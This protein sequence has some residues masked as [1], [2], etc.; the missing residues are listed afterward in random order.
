MLLFTFPL[1]AAP[2]GVMD[3]GSSDE[4]LTNPFLRPKNRGIDSWIVTLE[5]LGN[6]LTSSTAAKKKLVPDT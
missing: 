3:R 6:P 5:V 1:G 2:K 4:K